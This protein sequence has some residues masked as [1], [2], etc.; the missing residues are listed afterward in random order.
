MPQGTLKCLRMNKKCVFFFNSP[1]LPSCFAIQ[2]GSIEPRFARSFEVYTMKV[3]L[4]FLHFFQVH[5]RGM[6]RF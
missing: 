5:A 4:V 1:P 2:W 3:V 6:D